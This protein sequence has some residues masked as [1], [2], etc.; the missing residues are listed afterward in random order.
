MLIRIDININQKR[1]EPHQTSVMAIWNWHRFTTNYKLQRNNFIFCVSF[2]EEI[3]R[4]ENTS[5]LAKESV[6]PRSKFI[7][8]YKQHISTLILSDLPEF[9][10]WKTFRC[11]L[12]GAINEVSKSQVQRHFP[13]CSREGQR[14]FTKID[15][16]SYKGVQ[17]SSIDRLNK[18]R[19]SWQGLVTLFPIVHD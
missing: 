1:I 2:Q 17:V 13:F 18:S 14:V 7:D 4:E 8:S 6:K 5:I 9:L 11:S 12:H 16:K 15:T 10:V 19:N 3:V